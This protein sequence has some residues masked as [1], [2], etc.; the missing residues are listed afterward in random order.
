VARD[1]SRAYLHHL[2]KSNEF[3]GSMMLSWANV[4]FYQELM[5]AI[6]GAIAEGRLAELAEEHGA[7]LTALERGSER[8]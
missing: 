8:D 4:W 3:L 6:R 5:A 1:Y 2:V 7:R